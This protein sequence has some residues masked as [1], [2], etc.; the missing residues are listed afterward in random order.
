MKTIHIKQA[1][2]IVRR[3]VLGYKVEDALAGSNPQKAPVLKK[4]SDKSAPT[5]KLTNNYVNSLKGDVRFLKKVDEL[6]EVKNKVNKDNHKI[7]HHSAF[8]RKTARR[9]LKNL[10][11]VE[12]AKEK[13]LMEEL[14]AME[15][16]ESR[17]EMNGP[18]DCSTPS[19]FPAIN[20]LLT[21]FFFRMLTEKCQVCGEQILPDSAELAAKRSKVKDGPLTPKRVYCSHW[22]HHKCLH[23]Y[24]TKPP[25]GKPCP[26]CG[27]MVYHLDWSSDV[28]KLEKAW[29]TKQ[30][31]IREISEVSDCFDL[32]G[33]FVRLDEE[34]TEFDNLAAGINGGDDDW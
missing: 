1:D 18:G 24:L 23:N 21:S 22:Y 31:R 20:F 28:K 14:E 33:E 5:I 25:F 2:E 3:L 8:V 27:L 17:A 13:E 30:A 4:K 19:L 11:K 26:T 15:E 10:N 6:R 9:A 32:G 16:A 12:G 29:A 34:E 7:K